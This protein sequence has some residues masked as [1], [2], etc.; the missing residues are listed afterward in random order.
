MFGCCSVSCLSLLVGTIWSLVAIHSF[1]LYLTYSIVPQD[2]ALMNDAMTVPV[3][4]SL[5]PRDDPL[6]QKFKDT[7]DDEDAPPIVIIGAGVSGIFAAVALEQMGIT[8]YLIVE[9]SDRL[10]GRLMD[11]RQVASSVLNFADGDD[12]ESSCPASKPALFLN[13]D[14]PLELG[15]EWIHAKDG[16][17]AVRDMLAFGQEGTTLEETS[18]ELLD[19]TNFISYNPNWYFRNR[20]F[21]VLK[22]LYTETKWNSSTWLEYLEKCVLGGSGGA[23][24]KLRFNTPVTKIFYGSNSKD[25]SIVLK[26]GDGS[27]TIVA[28]RVIS[29]IPLG[30]L[31][32]KINDETTPF[33]DPPLSAAKAKAIQAV[34]MPPGYRVLFEMNS[35]FYPD[36]TSY[37]AFWPA[38]WSGRLMEGDI[39]L[40]YD[41]L[42]GKENPNGHFVIAYVAVGDHNASLSSAK[43]TTD[44]DLVRDALAKLDELFD[45]KGSLHYQSHVIQNWTTEPYIKGTYS[46][47]A[48]NNTE[49]RQNL[50]QS[51]YDGRLVFA[52]EHTSRNFFSL[53]PGAAMEGRRA[54]VEAVTGK[55]TW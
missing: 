13:G 40:F 21:G 14:I 38:V 55:A 48:D 51:E 20:K 39:S 52:G 7:A 17:K 2:V 12:K 6:V 31:K 32:T 16:Q 19:D 5:P 54:A 33:F 43:D 27:E 30:V 15:A 1:I 45:G 46:F 44:D 35:K 8:N 42:Y 22:A 10:G 37:E 36:L 24:D 49:N 25:S 18:P 4:P 26:I 53:V 11:T 29:T 47:Y 3:I 28:S 34:R 41:P 23:S 50:A 9:A